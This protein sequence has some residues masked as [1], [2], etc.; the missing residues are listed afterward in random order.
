MPGWL[1][2]AV[3]M[4]VINMALHLYPGTGMDPVTELRQTTTTT[5]ILFAIFLAAAWGHG[6]TAPTMY[7]LMGG[8]L[9]SLAAVPCF[10]GVA[11]SLASR[12]PWWGQPVLIYGRGE[13]AVRLYRHYMTHPALGLR[14][15]AIV[16][17]RAKRSH[18][19]HTGL[20]VVTPRRGDSLR[21]DRR[22]YWAVVTTPL[23]AS[24]VSACSA[25][26]PHVLVVRN[27]ARE[28][29]S[30]RNR[31]TAC[32][33]LSRTVLTNQLLLP[34]NRWGKTAMD[35]VVAL[36]V[37]ILCLPI[38]ACISMVIKLTSPGPIFYAQKRIG[39]DNR[40]IWAW[41]FRTMVVNGE[42]VLERYLAA[43]PKARDEW[44]QDHKLKD[45][46]RVTKIGE[47][48]RK[49]SLDELPQIWNVF[50]GE[51]SLVG[52]RPIVTAEISKYG[53][54]FGLYTS[55]TPGITGLWQIS[56]RNNTTYDE[57]V[58]FDEYYA[59]NWSPWLDLYILARTI[60]VVL[61]REGAY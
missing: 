9:V 23:S 2:V 51:M 41:K 24:A 14:P 34:L 5:L 56:G 11:R 48:L 39:K 38:L 36:F 50:R 46:P 16:D 17:N 60:L 55:V 44:E 27:E 58:S 18:E 30:L 59:L 4:L 53:D 25:A 43:N 54:S 8:C 42:E 19:V 52:P 20:P 49:T 3:G 15:V 7:A 29:P 28:L 31:V 12:H 40:T 45:D 1:L 61:R 47:L 33:G 22:I 21:V 13:T 26:F 57:R 10:R 37:G 32:G 6:A 35:Y